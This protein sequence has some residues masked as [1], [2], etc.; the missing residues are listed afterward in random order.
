MKI[1]FKLFLCCCFLLIISASNTLA[2]SRG[3]VGQNAPEWKTSDWHQLPGGSNKGLNPADFKGK[4]IYLYFFQSW[5][6]GCHRSG[7]PT[8]KKMTEQFSKDNEVAFVVI[9]T[10]FEGHS[11]NDVSKLAKTADRYQLRIP[12]GQSSGKSGTPEIMRKYRSGGTPWTVLID[13]NGKVR[14][15]DFHISSKK[16]TQLINTLKSEM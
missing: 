6:P 7:F 3:I 11:I 1:R 8:L 14:F 9:Q 16:A 2:Q 10:T 4:V 5:C 13:K 12:F 15:N